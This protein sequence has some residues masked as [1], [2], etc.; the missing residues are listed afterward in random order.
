MI[1]MT[2]LVCLM[3]SY[4]IM[5]QSEEIPL[6]NL[7]KVD[8][9]FYIS[10]ENIMQL[11]NYIQDLQEENNRLQNLTDVLNNSLAEERD[12]VAQLLAEKDNIITLQKQ[13]IVDYKELYRNKDPDIFEKASWAAGGA[14]IASLLLLLATI[15]N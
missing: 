8:G 15:G 10:D 3:I 9:G 2:L 1:L 4:P 5:A 11:A 6:E 14:G 7:Q 12:Q 13:Q